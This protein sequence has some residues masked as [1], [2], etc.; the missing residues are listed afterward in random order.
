MIPAWLLRFLPHIA[1]ALAVIGALLFV[2]HRGYARAQDDQKKLEQR[3]TA[4]IS[5]AVDAID[6]KT[7][8]RIADIDTTQRTIVQPV[9]TREII[10]NPRLSDP[11]LGITP[12]MRDAINAARAESAK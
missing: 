11:A 8:T 6:K 2:D 9:L 5:D 7:A 1:V 10:A 12:A 3:I 4:K